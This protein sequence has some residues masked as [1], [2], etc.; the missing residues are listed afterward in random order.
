MPEQT[1]TTTVEA[2]EA[3]RARA[4]AEEASA[5]AANAAALASV[6]AANVQQQA[7][8][9]MA[10]FESEA[11]SW[12]GLKEQFEGQTAGFN[13]RLGQTD[14]RLTELG[15]QLQ[16]I[17]DRLPPPP[18]PP[19]TNPPTDPANPGALATPPRQEARPPEPEPP[20]PRKRAHRWI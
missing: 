2:T 17:L 8:E 6:E 1:V 13:D 19:P 15:Q 14:S 7:A 10:A 11:T 5:A 12:R 18:A 3:E 9:R 20:V 4:A 16:S